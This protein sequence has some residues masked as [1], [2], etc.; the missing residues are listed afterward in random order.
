MR[1]IPIGVVILTVGYVGVLAYYLRPFFF[2][3]PARVPPHPRTG[4][5]NGPE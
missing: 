5:R 2:P 4:A 1:C 3:G